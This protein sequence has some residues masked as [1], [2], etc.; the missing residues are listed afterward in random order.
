VKSYNPYSL[1]NKTILVTGASSGIG[2]ATAIE[3]SKLGAE[4]IITGRNEERL[5]ETLGMLECE[6]PRYIIAD[7]SNDDDIDKLVQ[8]VPQLDGLVNNAGSV[9]TLPIQFITE[10]AI[11]E[12]FRVN[13]LAPV[14]LNQRLVKKKKLIKGSSIVYTCSICGV[15]CAEYA[16]SIYSMSKGAVNGFVKNAALELAEKNIRVN[17]VC[18]GMVETNILAKGVITE[19]QLMED[20]KRYPLK[21]HGKPEDIAYAIIYLL[22]DASSWV[23]GTSLVI[24]GG[25]LLK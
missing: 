17:A 8:D 23:T 7:L 25:F 10:E 16:N 12:I 15:F 9:K 14:L 4:V 2:K 24:D 21:R 1:E 11:S 22:S 3:C 18:P 5:K 19:E 13:A 20:A 6:N